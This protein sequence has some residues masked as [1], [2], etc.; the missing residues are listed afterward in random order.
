MGL[1][2]N[3]FKGNAAAAPKQDDNKPATNKVENQGVGQFRYTPE[4]RAQMLEEGMTNAEI[5][6]KLEEVNAKLQSQRKS[7]VINVQSGLSKP[8]AET[9]EERVKRLIG[10]YQAE[11]DNIVSFDDDTKKAK[12]QEIS[13]LMD[14]LPDDG[15]LGKLKNKLGSIQKQIERYLKEE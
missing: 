4:E 15:E 1:F 7:Q 11:L 10:Y 2:S 9:E 12:I 14:M 13:N 5:D 3:I 8:E 6:A